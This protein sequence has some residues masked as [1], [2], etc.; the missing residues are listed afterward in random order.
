MWTPKNKIKKKKLLFCLFLSQW[1]NQWQEST[2][3]IILMAQY[4]NVYFKVKM[5]TILKVLKFHA[6]I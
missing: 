5:Y 3:S 4:F 2:H 1:I 6:I